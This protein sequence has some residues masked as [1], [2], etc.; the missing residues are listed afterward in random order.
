MII[1]TKHAREKF[2]VLA[3][4]EFKVSEAEV[5]EAVTEPD[6]IDKSRFPL[7]IAQKQIDKSHVLRVVYKQETLEI[8]KIITFYPGRVKQYK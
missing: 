4:H 8:I 6:L 3:K 5:L 2:R 1:F 7:L